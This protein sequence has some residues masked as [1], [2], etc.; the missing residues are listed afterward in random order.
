MGKLI[1]ILDSLNDDI[2]E[3]VIHEIKVLTNNS[4]NKFI[5]SLNPELL[6]TNRIV[7]RKYECLDILDK[8][9]HR[10]SYTEYY[11]NC[12]CNNEEKKVKK[13]IIDNAF[14]KLFPDYSNII[15]SDFYNGEEKVKKEVYDDLDKKGI[16][17]D[18]IEYGTDEKNSD[19][20]DL[21]PQLVPG[22]AFKL[23]EGTFVIISGLLSNL[24]NMGPL[25][26]YYWCVCVESDRWKIGQIKP[27]TNY[28]IEKYAEILR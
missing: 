9:L 25:H 18:P 23:R 21:T 16:I 3:E 8:I 4:L 11:N 1:E 2:R 15:N 22:T 28:M 12:C 10:Q 20:K 7:E 17:P 27:F 26:D 6:A 24:K 5:K 19:S 14:T 13:V